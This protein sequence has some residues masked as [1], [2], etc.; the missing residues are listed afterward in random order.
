MSVTKDSIGKALRELRKAKRL[1]Q[2]EL[3]AQVQLDHVAISMFERGETLTRFQRHAPKLAK[4]LGPQIYL[5]A[6]QLVRVYLAEDL[7]AGEFDKQVVAALQRCVEQRI[8]TLAKPLAGSRRWEKERWGPLPSAQELAERLK[9]TRK[10][11]PLSLI[12]AYRI[13]NA[14]KRLGFVRGW[15]VQPITDKE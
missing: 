9:L 6:L 13:G 14:M 4:V 2:K 11:K 15:V 3:A 10:G 7:E 1:T 12:D 8:G 5:L